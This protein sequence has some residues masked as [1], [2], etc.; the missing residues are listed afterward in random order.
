MS[1]ATEANGEL[2]RMVVDPRS[3][4]LLEHVVS[5][6]RMS[7]L[8][9]PFIMSESKRM[10]SIRESYLIKFPCDSLHME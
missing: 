2:L 7:F 8:A 9:S 1:H 6:S 4:D 5:I 3:I 10:R